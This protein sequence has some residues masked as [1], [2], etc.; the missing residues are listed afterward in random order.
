MIHPKQ[1]SSLYGEKTRGQKYF[2]F[3]FDN[4]DVGKNTKY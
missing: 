1:S 3:G 4:L 2:D